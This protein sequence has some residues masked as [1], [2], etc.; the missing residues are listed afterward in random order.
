MREVF[1]HAVLSNAAR[2]ICFHNHPS[3][4]L[5]VSSEDSLVTERMKDAGELLGIELIDHI[6]IGLNSEYISLRESC[7]YPFANGKEVV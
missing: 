1:K 7:I 2:I 6:I 4:N 5:E 3:G